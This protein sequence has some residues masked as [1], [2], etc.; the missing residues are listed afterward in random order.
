MEDQP[1]YICNT[2]TG[3]KYKVSNS[4]TYFVCSDECLTELLGMKFILH[5]IHAL[6]QK[7]GRVHT[8]EISSLLTGW[9]KPTETRAYIKELINKNF[10]IKEEKGFV[11][12]LK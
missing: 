10:L 3:N 8:A 4:E 5:L 6:S 11:K 12:P 7:Y 9:L 1:C 2:I